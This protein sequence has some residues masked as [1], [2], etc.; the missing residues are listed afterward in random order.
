MNEN[1]FKGYRDFASETPFAFSRHSSIGCGGSAKIAFYPRSVAETT[2]LLQKLERDGIPYFVVG[3]M[4][5]ILPAD[6]G[7]DKAIVCMKSLNGVAVADSAF[8]YAGATSGALLSACK[9]ANKSGAE[10][11][12]GVPCTLGGALYMNAGAGGAYISEIVESVLVYEGGETRILSVKDCAYSYKK[13]AF[14]ENGG[15]IL[16]ASLRLKTADAATIETREEYYKDRRK[17]LPKGRSMGCVF[18]NPEGAFAGDLI[19]RSGLKGLRLGDAKVSEEH[20]N[21]IINDGNATARDI[22]ALISLIKNA[23]WSQYGVRLEE[24]IRYLT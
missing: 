6:E 9:R 12:S 23:V 15:V 4:T 8:V 1:T 16:G 24:E 19:E 5:N 18:K 20:A 17:H 3:N 21:F 13:S 7:T 10:F 2:A 11:L 14:M 22:R